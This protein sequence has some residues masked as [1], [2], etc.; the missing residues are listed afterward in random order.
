MGVFLRLGLKA[1]IRLLGEF[2]GNRGCTTV[3]VGPERLLLA[4]AGQDYAWR[5]T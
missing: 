2:H 1:G 5:G 4:T 3:E